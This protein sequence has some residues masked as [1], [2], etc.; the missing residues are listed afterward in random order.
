VREFV[1]Q[2]VAATN[3]ADAAKLVGLISQEAAVSSVGLG[4]ISRGWKAIQKATEDATASGARFKVT[5]GTI[6]VTLLGPDTALAVASMTLSPA[7]PLQPGHGVVTRDAPGAA[8]I[9]VKR[10]PEGLRLV[11]EHYSLGAR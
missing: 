2:Y 6:D 3:E 9:L 11:H 1:Q 8:T 10:F 7:Q 4:K 5:M